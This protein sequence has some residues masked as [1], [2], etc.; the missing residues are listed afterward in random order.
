MGRSRGGVGV[1]GLIIAMAI[2]TCAGPPAQSAEGP[3]K[4][5]HQSVGGGYD[6]RIY[7]R[8]PWQLGY[9]VS[10]END[11]AELHEGDGGYGTGSYG[12]LLA[13][14]PCTLDLAFGYGKLLKKHRLIGEENHD[15]VW[16]IL[17]DKEP[18]FRDNV[19][20][21]SD[22]YAENFVNR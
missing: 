6:P 4:V 2:S 21:F 15:K 20:S 22:G 14:R 13:D 1:V 12:D 18:K 5:Q 17:A 11:A 16:K 9:C 10:A 8:D 19:I 3:E 7:T